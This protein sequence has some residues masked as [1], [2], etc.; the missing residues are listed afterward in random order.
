MRLTGLYFVIE[1]SSQA[2]QNLVLEGEKTTQS[3]DNNSILVNVESLCFEMVN[4]F[5]KE[6]NVRVIKY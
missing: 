4:I 5:V 3:R 1:Y 6:I 2:Q